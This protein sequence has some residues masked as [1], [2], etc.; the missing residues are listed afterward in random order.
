M[1]HVLVRS[2]GV[3]ALLVG[4]ARA[5]D[6][7]QA[8]RDAFRPLK[9]P[10]AA[11][12]EKDV[13]SALPGGI[14]IE[15]KPFHDLVARFGGPMEAVFDARDAA[16]GALRDAPTLAE[17]DA[18]A[19]A[20]RVVD[21]EVEDLLER[22]AAV[23]ARY[24]EVYNL[25]WDASG[26]KERTTRKLAAVLI[27]IY[28]R[29]LEREAALGSGA[30]E[31]LGGL[32]GPTGVA[33][34]SR[35][36]TSDPSPGLRAAAAA[37]LGRVRG[38]D[39]LAALAKVVADDAEPAVRVRALRA[40]ATGTIEEVKDPAIAALGDPAWEV[41]A[42]AVALC[43]KGGV[44]DAVGPLI[45]ALE[46]ESGRL[47]QDI[48]DALF[49]LVGVRL[50]G[51]AALW[52]RWWGENQASVASRAQA[53]AAEG[54]YGK[55]L[56][57]VDDPG[58]DAAAS[59]GE[60]KG[61]TTA[62]FYGIETKSLRIA[63]VVD[64]SR[65][66]LDPAKERPKAAGAGKDPWVTPRGDSK[67]AIAKWQLHRAIAALPPDAAFD[68]IVYSESYRV[69]Q[70]QMVDASARSKAKAHEW[71]D[72]IVANGTTNT[73]D[74]L[75]RAF[76]LAGALPLPAKAKV[77]RPSLAADTFFV[78]SDGDPNRGR[79]TDLAALE[80]D[81]VR[82]AHAAR[83]V[84]HTVGIGEVAGSSFLASLAKRTGGRYVG[85]R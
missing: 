42:L 48:D 37:A 14:V 43:A 85:F 69:W 3:V 51:D 64:I 56:G 5:G 81:L 25:E 32:G 46:K 79:V 65:S 11:R 75:D 30:S 71:V 28:R 50:D 49:R 40:L 23:E 8:L 26:E 47:R 24:A 21:G 10:A 17:A 41:R 9:L 78:L 4:T 33:W 13:A 22:V 19:G 16:L 36:A 57:D 63:F 80:D 38:A 20:W 60:A 82:R 68:V 35:A 45:R 2:L 7:A 83:I 34:L 6:R 52:A 29:L 74:A 59:D 84:V 72:A 44:L 61:A 53:R 62:A 70:P 76:E 54:A 73:C 66:M 1:R 39:A 67:I 27:P 31:V 15:A 18:L 55:P 77:A 58:S 12:L